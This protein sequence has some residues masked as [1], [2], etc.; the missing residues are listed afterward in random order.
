MSAP[1]QCHTGA[2]PSRQPRRDWSIV[3]AIAVVSAAAIFPFTAKPTSWDEWVYMGLAFHPQPAGWMLNRFAHV[4]AMKP[5][6]WLAGDPFVGTRLYWCA[7]F[8]IA[9]GALVWTALQ[10]P[11]RRGRVIALTLFLFMGQEAFFRFPGVAYADYATMAV[12]TVCSCL[13]LGRIARG[14]DLSPFDAAA[15]GLLFCIGCKA[16]ETVAPALVLAAALFVSPSG[17]LYSRTT[18]KRLALCWLAGAAVA[19]CSIVALDG[20]FLHDALFSLRPSSWRSLL[21]YNTTAHFSESKYSWL[22]LML[23]PESFTSF[24]LYLGAGLAWAS[25]QP[26]RRLLF[27]YA[28]PGMFLLMMAAVGIFAAAPVIHRYT[29]AILPL[30]SL[31]AAL[32]T[33]HALAAEQRL[34]WLGVLIVSLLVAASP[35]AWGSDAR[36]DYAASLSLAVG[37]AAVLLLGGMRSGAAIAATAVGLSGTPAVARVVNDLVGRNVQRQGEARF[38][39]LY[40]VAHAVQLAPNDLL[41]VS[42]NVYGGAIRQPVTASIARLSFNVSLDRNP[43]TKDTWPAPPE[44]DYA[45][46]SF[47]EYE[48]WR[49][50]AHA[51]PDHAVVSDDR[52]VAVI[53][54]RGACPLRR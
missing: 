52:Q 16:K 15:L 11:A 47:A 24:A 46:V 12:I 44:A 31:L 36:V 3:F 54:L 29:I 19:M 7:L 18:A 35:A 37:S 10:L 32:A 20:F 27:V 38:A 50:G 51:R 34:P 21:G 1:A 26:D 39:G 13:V 8:G 23:Q 53:C 14:V 22:G 9:V 4:Y 41:F 5:F 17:Q 28:L 49:A 45:V 30:L 25:R 48:Q 6:M 40:Q 2:H 33:V 43:L 42:R